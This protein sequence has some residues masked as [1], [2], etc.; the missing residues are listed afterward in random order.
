MIN[1]VRAH[2]RPLGTLPRAAAGV[3]RAFSKDAAEGGGPLNEGHGRAKPDEEL[4]GR[5][6]RQ[7]VP[8]PA[9][10][11]T[12]EAAAGAGG[13]G[14]PTA[15]AQAARA[16][17]RRARGGG[18]RC[19]GCP[20]APQTDA[21]AMAPRAARRAPPS[22]PPAQG[23]SP[24]EEPVAGPE[25]YPLA[26][27]PSVAGGSPGPLGPDDPTLPQACARARA[28]TWERPRAADSPQ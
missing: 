1:I 16:E 21:V 8:S 25:A 22:R 26:N 17:P 20:T 14:A 3:A 19:D 5:P 18:Q 23:M 4:Y 15:P 12:Q 11:L 9:E 13:C 10:S 27:D 6:D 24:K 2:L 28:R 7:E